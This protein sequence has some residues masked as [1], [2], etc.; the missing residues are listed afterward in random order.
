[1][2]KA[3]VLFLSTIVFAQFSAD[4]TPKEQKG[5]SAFAFTY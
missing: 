3:F 4:A 1:M 2:K 5:F